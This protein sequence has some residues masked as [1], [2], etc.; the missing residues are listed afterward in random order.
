[1][2][3]GVEQVESPP[4]LVAQDRGGQPVVLVLA[5]GMAELGEHGPIVLCPFGVPVG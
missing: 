1:M 2:V 4:Q 5:G 3:A